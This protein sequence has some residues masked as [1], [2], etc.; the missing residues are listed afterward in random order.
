MKKSLLLMIMLTI[1]FISSAHAD[2]I[3]LS[4]WS[5]SSYDV[6]GAQNPGNWILSGDK[7]TVTQIVNADPSMY[8]NNLNQTAYKMEGTWQVKETGGDDDFMGFVF[9]YKDDSHFYLMDWKQGQQDYVGRTAFEGFSVKKISATNKSDLDLVDFWS[10]TDTTHTTILSTNYG[11]D[12]GWVDNTIYKFILDF[13]VAGFSIKVQNADG[14]ATLWDV[15]INDTSY[16][17]GQFGFYNFSQQDVEYSGFTQT[18]G[19][20]VDP[21]PEPATMVLFGLGL[22]GVAGVSRKKQE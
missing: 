6:A 13:T 21:V 2:Q 12:K 1:T 3:D 16:T 18:G 4:S 9:G 15:D 17:S 10:S 19:E 5:Y 8:L 11:G 20:I 7:K 22:L 14:T